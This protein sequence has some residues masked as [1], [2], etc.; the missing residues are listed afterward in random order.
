M[1]W[2]DP[3]LNYFNVSSKACARLRLSSLRWV[4]T[5]GHWLS[6]KNLLLDLR[7][8][9]KHSSPTPGTLRLFLSVG[10]VDNIGPV[11]ARCPVRCCYW[12]FFVARYQPRLRTETCW[13]QNIFILMLGGPTRLSPKTKTGFYLPCLGLRGRDGL[14]VHCSAPVPCKVGQFHSKVGWKS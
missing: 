9:H 7:T 14:T 11:G 4:A 8:P 2:G 10:R 12:V 6:P 3:S 1:G 5:L 13:S